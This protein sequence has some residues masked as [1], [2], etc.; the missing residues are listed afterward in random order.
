[1]A[2]L[3]YG[4]ASYS[5]GKINA[6]N[7]LN[8]VKGISTKIKEDPIEKPLP[9]NDV[10]SSKVIGSSV[11]LCSNTTFGFEISYPN[12][13]FTTYNSNES[14]CTFF[15]P[16][17]FVIPQSVEDN[18][19]PIKIAVIN[20]ADWENTLKFYEN[21]N[22][23]RN[24]KSVQNIDINSRLIKKVET[25]STGYGNLPKGLISLYY[26]VFDA[27]N[28]LIIAYTQKDDKENVDQNE[29]VLKEMAQSLKFF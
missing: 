27:K 3:A 14:Q 10:Q 21:P 8:Q 17:T 9:Y 1:M 6:N 26:L 22:E 23:F 28:P 24:V 20:S 12:D 13:W 4:A 5:L 29:T 11:K 15:A 16:F 7:N 2:A 25:E 19:T 18:L